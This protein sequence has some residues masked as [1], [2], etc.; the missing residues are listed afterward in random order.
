MHSHLE[1]KASMPYTKTEAVRSTSLQE[2]SA[3]FD[4]IFAKSPT[5][6]DLLEAIVLRGSADSGSSDN[7]I[8][9]SNPPLYDRISLSMNRMKEQVASGM[10]LIWQK[11]VQ[12]RS[13]ACGQRHAAASDSTS[14]TPH[15][16]RYHCSQSS[17]K[18]RWC[19]VRASASRHTSTTWPDSDS[20]SHS[21]DV[22]LLSP[23]FDST[24][25]SPPPPPPPPPPWL[26]QLRRR[27]PLRSGPS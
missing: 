26:W 7:A 20:C 11:I 8:E 9:W 5:R 6:Y 3:Q 18:P 25:L 14:C 19:P 2:S 13:P 1:S 16:D 15:A 27:W 4:P 17:Y 23:A 24:S 22:R 10:A 21:F 12:V